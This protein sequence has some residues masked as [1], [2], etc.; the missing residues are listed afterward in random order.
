[1]TLQQLKY[2]IEIVNSGSISTAA[3][4]LFI[5][6]PSLSNAVKSLEQ[7]FGIEI[8]IRTN[9]G[10]S[11]SSDGQNFLSY[12]RQ[13]LEQTDLLEKHYL[14]KKPSR[15]LFAISTQH[16]AFSVNAFVNLIRDYAEDEYEFTLRETKTHEILDDVKD[17]RS[18]IGV[19]YLSSFNEQVINKILHDN[20][21]IFIELFRTSPYIFMSSRHP[22][23]HKKSIN[24]SDLEPYPCLS[25][26]QGTHNSFYFS[27]EIHSTISHK[28]SIRVSDRA[29]LFN[30]V[31]GLNGYT[32]STGVLSEDLNGSNIISVPLASS[33]IIR[34]GYVYNKHTHLSSLAKNYI[35]KL[36]HYISMSVMP[37]NK[38]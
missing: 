11:L 15:R 23:A 17:M 4:K 37:Q 16:Y 31:I 5:S 9:R 6:Q 14:N 27:E 36:R 34:V 25:F 26:E 21:L 35:K 22:L 30:L 7:E 12:A 13:I 8:F 18:E 20:D 38:K 2:I 3:Q 33:E 29:T 24:F 19:I 10:V 28:K 1:M 32:I